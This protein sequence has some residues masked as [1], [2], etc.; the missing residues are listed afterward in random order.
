M[1]KIFLIIA[2]ICAGMPLQSRNSVSSQSVATLNSSYTP[3]VP[4]TTPTPETKIK[5]SS[6]GKAAFK[7]VSFSYNQKVFGAVKAEKIAEYLWENEDMKPDSVEPEHRNFSF[8]LPKSEF[9]KMYL[10]VYPLADFPRMY[11]VSKTYE[12]DMK[13][14]IADLKKVLA[15]KDFRVEG[16]IPF[17][18]YY[19]A[20]QSFQAKV[21]HF[22]FP[23]GEGILF[24]T[25]WSTESALI[26][27]RQMRYVFEGIT[28]DKKYY[29]VAEMPVRTS[30]LPDESPDEFEG[31]KTE[32]LSTDCPDPDNIKPRYKN[33]IS[34]IVKR[35]ENLPDEKYRP[36]LKYFEEIIS[37][38]KIEQ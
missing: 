33:Y 36:G 13:E 32:Y 37:S 14:E 7:G 8:E 38:L 23:D 31:Y 20:S 30:F 21:K 12:E 11:A 24:L 2:L 10:A 17:L 34:N 4:A 6:N 5:V 16:E 28:T 25:H 1:S 26:S 22:S 18:R 3:P 19:D 9:G 15:D 29:V 35:M 27:N